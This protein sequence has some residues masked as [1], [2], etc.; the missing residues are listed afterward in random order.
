MIS[1]LVR[2]VTTD[3]WRLRVKALPPRKGFFVQIARIVILSVRGYMEDNCMFR[4]SALTFFTMLSIV[5]VIAVIFAIAN[6][7][8][9]KDQVEKQIRQAF[10]VRY[11]SAEQV[12]EDAEQ[13]SMQVKTG[14][15]AQ[16][17]AQKK[18]PQTEDQLAQDDEVNGAKQAQQEAVE[19]II[20][21]ANKALVI[22]S[23]QTGVVGI[24]I[25]FFFWTIIKVLGNIEDSFNHI[26]GIKRGRHIGRKFSDYLSVMLVCPI[27]LILSQ[28]ITVATN[29]ALNS[30]HSRLPDYITHFWPIIE[31]SLSL[32]KYFMVWF[33]FSF[34]FMFMPNTKVK[35]HSGFI[36]GLVAGTIFIVVQGLYI[37]FQIGVAKYGAIYGSFATLPLFLIWL[38]IS[39]FIVL[40]GA[41]LAFAL[42]NVDTYEFEPDCLK[43]SNSLRRLGGLTITQKLVRNFCDGR[44]AISAEQMSAEIEMPVR[45]V[46]DIL[47]EL[48][49]CGIVTEVRAEEKGRFVGYQPGMDVDQMTIRFVT[50]KLDRHGVDTMPVKHTDEMNKIEDC[51]KKMQEQIAQSDC[52]LLLKNI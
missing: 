23:G 9:L 51:L 37:K 18:S 16:S 49:E 48:V 10:S 35:F 24:A 52:N 42:Q 4:A 1:R 46:R 30:L 13:Q 34:L 21:F 44:P 43:A 28:S 33:V 50:D 8:G 40:F 39:W 27:L 32:S 5:P 2:F 3:I 25:A 11:E 17:D 6:G 41:E 47:Y 22:E 15:N 29:D 36:A 12:G 7:F 14:Q 26:W 19:Y 45:L 20:E 38:Q 31:F